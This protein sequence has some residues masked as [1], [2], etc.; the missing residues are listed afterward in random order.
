MG[1]WWIAFVLILL[2]GCGS[3]GD[4][5]ASPCEA[6]EAKLQECYGVAE[7]LE[8]C[9]EAEAERIASLSC[10]E[11]EAD[12]SDTKADGGCPLWA[13]F[14]PLLNWVCDDDED[15]DAYTCEPDTY[16][17]CDELF[18][19]MTDT[20]TMQGI[21]ECEGGM[22]ANQELFYVLL[23]GYGLCSAVTNEAGEYSLSVPRDARSGKFERCPGGGW[24]V[25]GRFYLSS[26]PTEFVPEVVSCPIGAEGMAE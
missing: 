11:L 3:D 2:V 14:I 16:P 18:A 26:D 21:I 25:S 5:S 22:P 24:P 7:P 10:A 13:A 1:K 12:A 19:E 4:T 23:H 15:Y 17:S 20:R 8:T 6:A 9:D